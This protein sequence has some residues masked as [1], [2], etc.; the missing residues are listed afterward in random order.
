M[1][2]FVSSVTTNAIQIEPT[3]SEDLVRIYQLLTR[4]A[5]SQLD[6]ADAAIVSIAE[7]LNVNRIFTFDR[8]DFSIIRPLHC[9]YFELLPL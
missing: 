2:R 6:F 9:D 1:R 4:Y 7:R 5:D 8:R 3:T